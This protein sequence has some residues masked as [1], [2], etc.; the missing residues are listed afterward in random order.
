M[1][2]LQR[3][4]RKE[5]GECIDQYVFCHGALLW[6]TDEIAHLQELIKAVLGVSN[7]E[8]SRYILNCDV[9]GLRERV[10]KRTTGL[11]AAEI[12]EVCN[13]LTKVGEA[14]DGEN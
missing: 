1:L 6:R 10:Q 9:N 14:D 3:S 8:F 12:D 13:I 4:V 11:T 7:T 2:E 5:L